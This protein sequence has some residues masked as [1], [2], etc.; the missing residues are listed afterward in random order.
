MHRAVN[1]INFMQCSLLGLRP[2]LCLGSLHR[3]ACVKSMAVALSLPL[4]HCASGVLYI[5]EVQK[6]HMHALQQEMV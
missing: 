1:Q 3:G 5:M 2:P 6:G 4:S